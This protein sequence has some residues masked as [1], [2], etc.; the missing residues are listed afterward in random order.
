MSKYCTFWNTPVDGLT[1]DDESITGCTILGMIHCCI[2]CP[3]LIEIG[4]RKPYYTL[5]NDWK[6][7][8]E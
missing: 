5:T 4:E 2:K 7:K 3:N 6:P 1:V 8:E